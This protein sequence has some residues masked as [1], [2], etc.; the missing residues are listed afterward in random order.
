[1]LFRHRKDVA[2]TEVLGQAQ[3]TGWNIDREV[4]FQ[5]KET[6]SLNP[7]GGKGMLT[8]KVVRGTLVALLLF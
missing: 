2:R 8:M 6:S 1:M 4:Y 7:V 5:M 3:N